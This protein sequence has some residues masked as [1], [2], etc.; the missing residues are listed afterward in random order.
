[1][2]NFLVK[3]YYNNIDHT[4]GA[5]DSERF[6]KTGDIGFFDDDNS[7]VIID[8]KKEILI[9]KSYTVNTSEIEDYIL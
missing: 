1:M 8:R 2:Y 3:C 9:Y 5:V 4:Q 7:P 6:F